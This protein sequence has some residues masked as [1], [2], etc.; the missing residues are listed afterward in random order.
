MMQKNHWLQVHGLNEPP[1]A[2]LMA[3]LAEQSVLAWNRL[4]PRGTP[5]KCYRSYGNEQTAFHS[6]TRS[7]AWVMGGHSAMVM[8]EGHGGGFALTH[9][10]PLCAS[11][12]VTGQPNLITLQSCVTMVLQDLA[13]PH[14][15]EVAG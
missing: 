5:V 2:K 14:G 15:E 4:Y 1:G 10:E 7:E 9:M 11:S 13:T 8:I 3:S 6:V 12:E